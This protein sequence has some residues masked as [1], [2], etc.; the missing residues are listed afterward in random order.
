MCANHAIQSDVTIAKERHHKQDD[1]MRAWAEELGTE[2]DSDEFEA[3]Y[4]RSSRGRGSGRR[5]KEKEEQRMSKAE[6]AALKA[7]LKVSAVPDIEGTLY[8][9]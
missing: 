8:L 6:V 9:W 4:Q 5:Q 1:T 2:Y 7:E 3:E